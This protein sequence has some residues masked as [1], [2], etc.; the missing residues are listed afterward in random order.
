MSAEII[1]SILSADFANLERDVRAATDAGIRTVQIDVM[2]GRF[3]PNISVGLPVVKALKNC[4]DAALDVHL[5][6]VEPE[7]W[8]E[9]FA[10]A[11]AD[12][13]TIHVEASVHLHRALERIRSLGVRAGAAINPATPA[14][15]LSEVLPLL[16]V[17]LVMSVNPGFGGQRFID[18]VLPKITALRAALADVGNG[19]VVQVDGGIDATT[20]GRAVAAGAMQ[21]VAGSAV[22]AAGVPVADAIRA[23]REAAR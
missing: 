13:I 14:A 9:P 3:V 20:I 15:A 2:D 18:S 10:E 8:I 5:M 4:S 1:P 17:A 6:I 21:C 22:F 23:L 19:G 7:R 12:V 16:D 11:G